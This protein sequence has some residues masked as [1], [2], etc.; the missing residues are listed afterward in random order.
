MQNFDPTLFLQQSQKAVA[1]STFVPQ[2]PVG[3]Y[4]MVVDKVTADQFP[5]VKDPSKT[6]TKVKF[7][8]TV[9]DPA[10]QA[11]LKRDKV[12]VL[13]DFLLEMT[14]DGTGIDMAEGKNVGL[15]RMREA[16][17]LNVPGQEWSFGMF[18]GR[19]LKGHVEHEVYQGEAY[20]KVTKVA[21]A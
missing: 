3:D 7:A 17:G 20:A 13:H 6:Y 8:L 9:N 4:D 15:G 19:P 18:V 16:T 2:C 12:V 10:V 14:E 11:F 21:K 5:G 1:N